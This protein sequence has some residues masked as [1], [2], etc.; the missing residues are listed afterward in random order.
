M[1]S[2]HL[3]G[4]T[5]GR[6]H[7]GGPHTERQLSPSACNMNGALQRIE[8]ACQCLIIARFEMCIKMFDIGEVLKFGKGFDAIHM[9]H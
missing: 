6:G 8:G 1:G 7:G 5:P 9:G 4:E 2:E 3:P